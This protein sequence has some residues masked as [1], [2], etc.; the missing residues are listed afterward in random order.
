MNL[1]FFKKIP[2]GG[3]IE[4]VGTR[5]P[6]NN[7]FIKFDENH[8]VR[9]DD[10]GLTIQMSDYVCETYEVTYFPKEEYPELYL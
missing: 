2:I 7:F 10:K 5:S 9:P 3:M 4:I 1:K 8:C 6:K